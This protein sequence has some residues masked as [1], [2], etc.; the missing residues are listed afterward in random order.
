M[1]NVSQYRKLWLKRHAKYE[2][3][4]FRLIRRK[5]KEHTAKI[6][7]ENTNQFNVVAFLEIYV[8]LE[9]FN[10]IYLEVYKEVGLSHGN[11]VGKYINKQIGQKD[12]AFGRFAD[13][14]L[15]N[16][17]R[18]LLGQGGARIQSVRQNYI[19]FLMELITKEYNE[20]KTT[21]EIATAIEKYLRS[22][23][24]YRYQ[25]LRI[26]RTET[27]TAS[28]YAAVTASSVSGVQMEKVWISAQDARTRRPPESP[29]DHYDMNEVRVDLEKPFEVSGE[30]L[31]YPGDQQNGSAGNVINCRCAVAQVVKRDSNGNIIRTQRSQVRV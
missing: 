10:D 26:A 2:L 7:F 19:K 16:V 12:F 23:N 15:A 29:F 5:L 25:A 1:N 4:A 22:R 24:F 31:M 9:V 18:M 6:P 3:K 27:T 13:E 17:Q 8:P 30:F 11:W 20:G 28:N 14:F 21:S